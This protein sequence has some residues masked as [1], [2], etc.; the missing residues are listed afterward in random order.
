MN[1]ETEIKS[2]AE[3]VI[4]AKLKESVD[5]AKS[6]KQLLA[7]AQKKKEQLENDAKEI[8][9]KIRK[10]KNESNKADSYVNRNKD[11]RLKAHVGGMVEMTGLLRYEYPEG[12]EADNPQDRLIANLLVGMFL[13]V[14]QMLE[15]STTEELE[16]YWKK[17]K[18]FRNKKQ[19]DRLL[20]KVNKDLSSLFDKLGIAKTVI[21]QQPNDNV[22]SANAGV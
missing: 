2:E 17:G 20:P 15:S 7:E 19:A 16:K 13:S 21:N 5:K 14:S 8:S 6:K 1:I 18:D 12:V 4:E 10:L 11:F 3:L 22:Q 9:K